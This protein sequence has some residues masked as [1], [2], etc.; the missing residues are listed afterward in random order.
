MPQPT[1]LMTA[2]LMPMIQEQLEANFEVHRYDRADD[3]EA[4]LAEIGDRVIGVCHGGH[5]MHVDGALMDRLPNLKLVSNFGVGYDGVD[6]AAART[7]G[8]IITNTPDVLTEEVADTALGLLIMTVRELPQA[9]DYLHAGRWAKEG[10]YRLTPL[11]LRDRSIGI[12]GLGRIGKAIAKRCEG[13]G[14]AISY[15]GRRQQDG[16]PYPYYPTAEKLAEAVDTLICITPGTAETLNLVNAPVLEALGPRGV[17]INVSRGSVVDEAALMNALRDG[18]IAAA[19]L[20]VMV[21]EPNINPEL[22]QFDNLVLLPHVASASQYTRNRM[23]QLVV[24]NLLAL[25]N[26]QPPLSPVPE[27][28]FEAW[29]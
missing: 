2:G 7:R 15:M 19:G 10:D 1:V 11:S 17:L 26:E 13:F 27:T 20:D 8:I 28:P 3:R 21:G 25:K 18:T 22:M 5:A 6:T 29:K 9:R 16:V 24:D 4:L 12:I 14:L 23:G